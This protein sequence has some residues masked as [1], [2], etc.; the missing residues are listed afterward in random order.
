MMADS[1]ATRRAQHEIRK[2]TLDDCAAIARVQARAFFD[3]PLQVW[4]L[5][6]ATTRLAILERVFELLSRHASVPAGESYTDATCACAAFWVPPGG[7]VLG[8]E[9]AAAMAPILEVLGEDANARFRAAE[10]TMRARRPSDPHFYLQG[11]GVDPPRQDEGLG[12]AVMQPVL[13][14]C[15]ADRVLGYLETTKAS[16]VGFYERHGFAVV[17]RTRLPLDGPSM[18]FMAR[19]PR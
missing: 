14:R 12:S 8:R 15:D 3:D 11:L 6:D 9:A 2:M 18:W 16:N 5:P 7:F 19:E 4:A 17:G 1:T 10:D 13:A